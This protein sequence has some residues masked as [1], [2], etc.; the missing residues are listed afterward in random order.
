ML[1]HDGAPVVAMILGHN[2]SIEAGEKVLAPARHFGKPMADTVVPTPYNVRQT[3]LD[4]PLAKHGLHRYWR[5]AFTEQLSD[6]LIDELVK[7]AAT[8]TSPLSLLGL[9]YVHGAAAR[10]PAD[11][12]AFAA[13]RPQWDFDIIGQWTDPAESSGHIA[14]VRALWDRLEPQLLGTVYINHLA[15]D[16]RPEKVRVSYG[17]NYRRLRELKAVYDPMNLFRSNANISPA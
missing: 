5:S 9:F 1:T 4:D 11:A 2:G 14:W 13:R 3:L 6:A 7:G 15:A 12:T 8:F 17:E 16:D 10:V